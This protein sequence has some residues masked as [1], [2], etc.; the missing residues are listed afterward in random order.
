MRMKVM[1]S[2]PPAMSRP[3]SVFEP[4]NAAGSRPEGSVVPASSPTE[5]S[6]ASIA[7]GLASVADLCVLLG[8]GMRASYD[9]TMSDAEHAKARIVKPTRRDPV[10][11]AIV[12]SWRSLTGGSATRDDGRRTLV[13]C[14]G[15]ADSSAL[16]LALAA[17]SSGPEVCHVIHD[18]RPEHDARGDAERTRDLCDALGVAYHERSVSIA[19]AGGNA[20]AS[21][22]TLRY[23]ALEAVARERGLRYIATGHHADDQLETLLMRM[24]RGAG[25]R[26]MAGISDRRAMGDGVTLVRPMLGVSHQDARALCANAGWEWNEDATNRDEDRLR[27]ALRARV[28]PALREIEPAAGPRAARTAASLASADAAITRWADDVLGST[29]LGEHSGSVRLEYDMFVELPDSVMVSL[30]RRIYTRI[31]GKKGLDRLSRAVLTDLFRGVCGAGRRGGSFEVAE[32][33]LR[34]YEGCIEFCKK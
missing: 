31:V 28:L 33:E 19:T 8:E 12:A 18:M 22:R 29:A 11:R 5:V 2:T 17:V 23:G 24:L 26:G 1:M 7:P 9:G 16:L 6:V 20:E 4:P 27:A 21:A 34:I 3:A 32:L 13:A 30:L 14:S 10:V 25:V 15:G